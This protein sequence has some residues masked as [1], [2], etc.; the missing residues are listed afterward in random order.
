MIKKKKILIILSIIISLLILAGIGG[1][2][3]VNHTFSVV[4]DEIATENQKNFNKTPPNTKID[5]ASNDNKN[6]INSG[7][8]NINKNQDAQSNDSSNKS[9]TDARKNANNSV[10]DNQQ[11]LKYTEESVKQLESEVSF[12]DKLKVMSIISSSLSNNEYLE[13]LSMPKGGITSDEISRAY[14]ILRQSLSSD[15][16]NQI[17]KIY[18]KYANLLN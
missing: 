2:Y 15:K 9:E 8:G 6:N 7:S 4:F 1:I 5:S 18:T 12:S 17:A 14:L 11:K 13:L 10:S 16:K 3:F